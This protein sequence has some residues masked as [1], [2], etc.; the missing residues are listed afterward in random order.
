[1]KYCTAKDTTDAKLRLQYLCDFCALYGETLNGSRPSV[2]HIKMMFSSTPFSYFDLLPP[3]HQHLHFPC[4]RSPSGRQC[5]SQP[6][7][8]KKVWNNDNEMIPACLLSAHVFS[9]MH[10]TCSRLVS[11]STTQSAPPRRNIS[12]KGGIKMRCRCDLRHSKDNSNILYVI[13]SNIFI[14]N[15]IHIQK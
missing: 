10:M 13:T 15:S 14:Y 11:T 9:L 1:M 12:K 6:C 3:P 4:H 2:V 5:G 8:F 7:G